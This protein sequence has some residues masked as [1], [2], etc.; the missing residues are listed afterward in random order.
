MLVQARDS[1]Q[2]AIK[3]AYYKQSREWHPDKNLQR[4]EEATERFKLISEAFQVLS[5][6]QLR[7]RYDKF[8]KQAVDGT[9]FVD[10][11]ELFNMAFGGGKFEHLVGESTLAF[12]ARCL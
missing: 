1:S 4:Q 2:A 3:K 5:D 10:P 9:N 12:M 6:P 7:A 11:S 8:G